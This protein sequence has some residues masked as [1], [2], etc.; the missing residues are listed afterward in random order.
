MD[1]KYEI[2][3]KDEYLPIRFF[4]SNDQRSS[5]VPPHWH[6]Y[7]EVIYLLSGSLN[8]IINGQKLMLAPDNMILMHPNHIHATRSD[9]P[10]TT[11][12]V[13]QIALTFLQQ[14][15]PEYETIQFDTVLCSAAD[16]CAKLPAV[17]AILH[18]FYLLSEDAGSYCNIKR[19]SLLFDIVY[20]FARYFSAP[21]QPQTH[22]I[23]ADIHSRLIAITDYINK[24]FRT[25]LSLESLADHI[26][27]SPAYLSRF[28]K[29]YIGI[30]F[31]GYMDMLRLDAAYTLV[32]TTKEPILQI[33]DD[34][35]FANYPIFVKKFQKIY[36]ST[37][38]KLR[39]R[40]LGANNQDKNLDKSA[41][42]AL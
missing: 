31:S 22:T 27:L 6:D 15:Y 21:L 3:P 8:V 28:F 23:S 18:E 11:A 40:N 20:H 25:T 13:L 29:K 7:V 30:N 33:A 34:C 35:G 2:V 26:G 5:Y 9:D 32:T 4:Y 19:T 37:P 14:H 42:N 16:P 41:I 12:Y 36:G 38:L 17:R 1:Y 39:Q 24:N 10:T